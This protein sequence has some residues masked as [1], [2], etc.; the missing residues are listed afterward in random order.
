MT[1]ELLFGGIDPL[2]DFS[3]VLELMAEVPQPRREAMIEALADE[4]KRSG[5]HPVAANMLAFGIGNAARHKAAADKIV[6]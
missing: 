5:M 3:A 1:S 2:H 6:N 4:F